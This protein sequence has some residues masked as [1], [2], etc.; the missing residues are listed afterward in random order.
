MSNESEGFEILEFDPTDPESFER[1]LMSL[2]GPEPEVSVPA[3]VTVPSFLALEY[4]C[5]NDENYASFIEF[6]KVRVP[7]TLE[8]G[9]KSGVK[10]PSIED[11]R[12]I[13]TLLVEADP[14]LRMVS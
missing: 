1:M 4:I 2:F 8:S 11:T 6:L 9:A 3:R 12:E 14:A 5:L 7:D 10:V 13:I